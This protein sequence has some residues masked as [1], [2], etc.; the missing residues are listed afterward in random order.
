MPFYNTDSNPFITKVVC[1]QWTDQDSL[2]VVSIQY[3]NLKNKHGSFPTHACMCNIGGGVFKDEVKHE[4]D[5]PK[6]DA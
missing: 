6:S 4:E 3:E 1:D 2:L 5:F